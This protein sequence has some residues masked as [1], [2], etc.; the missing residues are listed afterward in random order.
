MSEGKLSGY[1]EDLKIP[2]YNNLL[3]EIMRK[4]SE[5]EEDE[6]AGCVYSIMME[7]QDDFYFNSDSIMDFDIDNKIKVDYY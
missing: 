4:K 5:D 3:K 1:F 6:E 2:S 7:A